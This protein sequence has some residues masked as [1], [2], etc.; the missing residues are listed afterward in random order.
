M[1]LGAP[2]LRQ[3]GAA[4]VVSALV[5]AC[6]PDVV[7][8]PS[9]PTP[10]PSPTSA[11]PTENALEREQRLAFEG[12]EKA[13]RLNM[14]EQ[15]RVLAAGGAKQP[16]KLIRDTAA[17][18]YLENVI[19]TMRLAHTEKWRID[20]PTKVVAVTAQTYGSDSV[21]LVGCEDN[22]SV[23]ILY[24]NGRKVTPAGSRLYLQSLTVR[25]YGSSW[26]VADVESREVK[27]FAREEGCRK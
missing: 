27:S 20:N 4:I 14:T 11:S 7:P 24:G 12:A 1:K 3:L 8:P 15:N 18:A 23:H 10:T 2:A 13:Y 16:P 17:G 25:K 6:T 21:T 5:A 9:S 26:K 22:R 19:R